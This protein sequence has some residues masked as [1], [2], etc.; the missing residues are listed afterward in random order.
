MDYLLYTR[1]DDG[2]GDN[3]DKQVCGL[4]DNDSNC[5][6]NAVDADGND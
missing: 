1:G 3:E 2:G 4:C 5:G 6:N